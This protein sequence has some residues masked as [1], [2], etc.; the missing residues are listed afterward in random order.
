[1][2]DDLSV[3]GTNYRADFEDGSEGWESEGFIRVNNTIP[4]QFRVA[5]VRA[6][7]PVAV[8]DL[9]LDAS[10]RAWVSLEAGEEVVLIVMGA[11]RHTRQPARYTLSLTR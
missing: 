3:I 1:M 8:E 7:E 2:I 11:T 6:V 5:V 9:T 10:N 4:Q